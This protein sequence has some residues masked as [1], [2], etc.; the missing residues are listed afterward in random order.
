MGNAP[1]T[2]G[3]LIVKMYAAPWKELSPRAPT[4]TAPPLIPTLMPNWSPAI[5]F[6]EFIAAV[7]TYDPTEV[8]KMSKSH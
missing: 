8:K 7:R 3:Q 1:I 4:M 6:P 2:D 5:T